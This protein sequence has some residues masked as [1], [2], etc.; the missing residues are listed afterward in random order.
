VVTGPAGDMSQFISLTFTFDP[1]TSV[2]Q[3]T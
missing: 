1:V 2:T 3:A